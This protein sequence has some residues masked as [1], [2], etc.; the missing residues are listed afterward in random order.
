MADDIPPPVERYQRLVSEFPNLPPPPPAATA[1]IPSDV[2]SSRNFP[3]LP[4]H[5][6]GTSITIPQRYQAHTLP[7]DAQQMWF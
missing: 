7:N 5:K 6:P 4:C 2:T 3:S 1:E